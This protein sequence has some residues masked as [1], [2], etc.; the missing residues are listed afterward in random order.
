MYNCCFSKGRSYCSAPLGKRT[1]L[2][3]ISLVFVSFLAGFIVP[4]RMIIPVAGAGKSD[5]NHRSF[6]HSPWGISGVHK[7][8]DIFAVEGAPVISSIRGLVIYK[9]MFGLGGNVVAVLG[10]KWHIHYYAHLD[11]IDI[12]QWNFIRQGQKI[13]T[14]GTTGNAVGKPPHLHYAVVTPI[15]YVW[16]VEAGK[17]GWKKMFYLNPDELL[18]N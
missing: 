6:W 2:M 5:W 16:R 3:I 10:P 4:E 11:S 15:P 13:G 17:Q 14:V 7:G 1:I 18:R 12:C 9:G 8:I